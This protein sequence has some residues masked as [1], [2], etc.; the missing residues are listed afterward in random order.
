MNVNVFISGI[1]LLVVFW[2]FQAGYFDAL[3]TTA[4]LLG[5]VIFVGVQ[6][7]IGKTLMPKPSAEK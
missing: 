4:W 1:V 2:A 3:G 7:F 5:V 6:W